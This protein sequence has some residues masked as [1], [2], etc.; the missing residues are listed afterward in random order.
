VG[1]EDHLRELDAL[2]D[3][4][5]LLDPTAAPP[6]VIISA[7]SGTAGVGKTALAVQWCHRVRDRFPDGQLF[8]DLRGYSASSPLRP[9]A[10]M[11]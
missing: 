11:T 7:I 2:L 9:I 10:P 6:A 4:D 8:L 1:R 5:S 3:P